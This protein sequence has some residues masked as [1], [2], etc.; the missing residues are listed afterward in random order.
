MRNELYYDYHHKQDKEIGLRIATRRTS[1]DLSRPQLAYKL[2]AY[3]VSPDI[4][5]RWEE[6]TTSVRSCMLIPLSH[7]LLC[8]VPYILGVQ[9]DAV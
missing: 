3:G 4:I 1:M 8:S 9:Q 2:S 5:K 6:G 7:A